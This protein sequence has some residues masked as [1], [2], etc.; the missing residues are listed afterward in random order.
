MA[1]EHVKWTEDKIRMVQLH[2]ALGNHSK[3]LDNLEDALIDAIPSA[4]MQPPETRVLKRNGRETR[5]TI[6]GKPCTLE[7]FMAHA[8]SKGINA[9]KLE[10][11]ITQSAG[12]REQIITRSAVSVG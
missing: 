1:K 11:R 12:E 7:Q 10:K 6:D 3:A 4:A 2:R 8:K 9:A 5:F